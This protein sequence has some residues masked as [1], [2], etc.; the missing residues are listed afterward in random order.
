VGCRKRDLTLRSIQP[1]K[2]EHNAFLERFNRPYRAEVLD[3]SICVSVSEAP[4]VTD[5]W[6][7]TSNAHPPHQSLGAL[8]SAATN[9]GGDQ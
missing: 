4:A 6:R 3:A 9:P 8:S 7:P 5:A 1:G 2:P